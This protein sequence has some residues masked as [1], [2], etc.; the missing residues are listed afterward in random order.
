MNNLSLL[1]YLAD[2]ADNVRWMLYVGFVLSA[3][4]VVFTL[5]S[6]LV[7]EGEILEKEY[8]PT[9]LKILRWS[10]IGLVFFG[11]VKAVVPTK[12]TVYAI[13]ASEV[14]EQVI[15]SPTAKKAVDALNRWLDKQAK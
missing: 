15:E 1:I 2:V 3:V 11:L 9:W 4:T 14:G 12:D 5:L 13:A 10:A 6:V 8:R 7:T